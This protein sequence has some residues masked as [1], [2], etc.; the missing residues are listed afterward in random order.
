MFGGGGGR[1]TRLEN[2]VRTCLIDGMERNSPKS[3]KLLMANIPGRRMGRLVLFL[4]D[5]KLR[6]Q[7]AGMAVGL[8]GRAKPPTP[9]LCCGPP[10]LCGPYDIE[11][12]D[13][14]CPL[15]PVT[16]RTL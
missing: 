13:F 15:S 9:P 12:S 2:M 6:Q 14:C 3:L 8:R 4:H 11:G 16:H 7:P 10:T 1:R 5:G